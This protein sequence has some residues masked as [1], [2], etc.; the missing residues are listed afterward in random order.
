VT[1][2]A[3]TGRRS[4]L[5]AVIEEAR[6]HA[7]RR[8]VALAGLGLLAVL[9]SGG[10]WAGLAFT[11]GSATARPTVPPGFHA[12]H[13]R[14]PVQHAL[15]ATWI[16][17]LENGV[18]PAG[19]PVRQ[20]VELW[21]D[22]A[23]QV[24]RERE[25]VYGRIHDDAYRCAGPCALQFA[26]QRYWPVD[27]SRFVRRPG[28][29]RYAGRTVVWLGVR[30]YGFEPYNFHDGEWIAIDARTH[31]PVA[32]RMYGDRGKPVSEARLVRRLPDIDSNRFWF[33]VHDEPN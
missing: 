7:R 29:A 9:V 30:R 16:Q 21:Y 26:F 27:A 32:S 24:L 13:A 31:H 1:E 2:L 25:R 14:G 10:V 23:A 8:R 6:R 3:T 33:V 20:K 4:L 15:V 18:K 28:L 19:P 11:G 5:A 17:T 22:S 12:V